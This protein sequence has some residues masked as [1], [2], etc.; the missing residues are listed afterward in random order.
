MNASNRIEVS[1]ISPT[2]GQHSRIIAKADLLP[3]IQREAYG[4]P[5]PTGDAGELI[6]NTPF[7]QVSNG[8]IIAVN[9]DG[10]G[11]A[12]NLKINADRVMLDYRG[13]ITATTQSGVGGNIQLNLQDSLILRHESS[14]TATAGGISNGGN[15]TINA[16]IIAGFENSDIIANAIKGRGG[17][18]QITTQS[19]FGLTYRDQLTPDNDITASSEFGINGNVQVKTIGI[20]PA[21]ALNTLPIDVVDSSRQIADRCGAAK[22]SSF[23]ATGRGGMPQGP[24]KKRGSDRTWNDLRDTSTDRSVPTSVILPIAQAK[25]PIVEASALRSNPD[26]SIELVAPM[27]SAIESGATCALQS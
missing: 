9:N 6:V 8:G 23:I 2:S 10:P 1:G 24:I 11:N 21:N 7:L 26:G 15:I 27:P 17:N 19:I 5:L 13:S 4:L 16:P 14:I 20:N 25:T 22:T 3:E 18:I 12:G